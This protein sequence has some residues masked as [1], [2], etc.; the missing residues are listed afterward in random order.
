MAAGRPVRPYAG[1]QGIPEGNEEFGVNQSFAE[2]V[3]STLRGIHVAP[4][5]I[6][7]LLPGRPLTC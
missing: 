6:A 5:H 7:R 1:P 4:A 2:G 3:S